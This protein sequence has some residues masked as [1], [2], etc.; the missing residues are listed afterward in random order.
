[1]TPLGLVVS[2]VIAILSADFKDFI[3]PASVW[4]AI[5]VISTV[6]CSCWLCY[7]LYLLVHNWEKGNIED[8]ISNI[9]AESEK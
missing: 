3:L 4:Y 5:F 2:C 8:I 7:T 6:I 9:I 1:M